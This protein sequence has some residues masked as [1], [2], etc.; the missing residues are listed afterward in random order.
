MGVNQTPADSAIDKPRTSRWGRYSVIGITYLF[1]ALLFTIPF[2]VVLRLSLTEMDG[3][4]IMAL[5]SYADGVINIRIKLA[6]DIFLVTDDLYV[7]TYISSMKFAL[8]NTLIC[9]AL[10]YPFA[11]FMPRSPASV[12]PALLMLVSLPLW[13]S[14]LLWVYECKGLLQG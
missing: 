5:S 13:P 8:I 6:N 11:Y 1:L 4:R 2:L 10:G 12:R 3:A 9:L 7:D 14:S